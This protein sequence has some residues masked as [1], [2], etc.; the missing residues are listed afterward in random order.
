MDVARP[1]LDQVM[2]FLAVVDEGSFKA[3]ARKLNRA[4]SAISYAIATLEAQLGILAFAREGSSR[5]VLTPAGR[6]I[7]PHARALAGEADELVAAVRAHI[8]GLEAEL[9]LAIDVM[10]PLAPVAAVLRDFQRVFPT[11]DL[12]LQVEGLGAVAALLLDERAHLAVAGP[13]IDRLPLLDRRALGTLELV[14]VAA[15]SHPLATMAPI[16]SGAARHYRQ[17]VLTDRSPLTDGREFGVL[18][19]RSWRL[20]DLAAKHALLLE[21]TGW[22]N[23]PRHMIA[24]DLATGRLVA[25][26]LPEGRSTAYPLWA[27]W[28]RDCRPGPAA[29]WMLDALAERLASP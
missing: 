4:V 21:G 22:G 10:C 1:T 13:V 25:L 3:A 16:P 9:C 29:K 7:L 23:M 27:A 19:A 18:A 8:G 26:D 11:V 24:D 5:P 12:R 14:P 15:R 28:R 20:G 6:A 2:A 17:L